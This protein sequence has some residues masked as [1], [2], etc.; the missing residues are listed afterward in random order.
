MYPA[1]V[2]FFFLIHSIN[3]TSVFAICMLRFLNLV[4]IFILWI[5]MFCQHI[6]LC[7]M[8]IP[9][10][11]RGRRGFWISCNFSYG[12]LYVIMWL[13]RN[14]PEF[15]RRA[16]SAFFFLLLSHFS[17]PCFEIFNFIFEISIS[18]MNL[19]FMLPDFS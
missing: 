17:N 12:Q 19:S 10:A 15:S 14:K 4:V 13:V 7:T 9:H 11:C 8:Y 5:G 18:Q 2:P 1:D 6:C 3:G 16:T